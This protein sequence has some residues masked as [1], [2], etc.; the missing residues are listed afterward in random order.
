MS[1]S[2]LSKI[3]ESGLLAGWAT[4]LALLILLLIALMAT[5]APW[6]GTV[7]PTLLDPSIR[8]QGPS[9]EHLLGTDALGR[10]LYSRIVYGARV[11]FVVG[12]GVLAVTAVFGVFFG[13]VSGYF[14]AADAVIMRVMDGIMAIPGILLAI[15]LVAVS[16]AS[17]M[18]VLIAIA[19]P[20]I[21]RMTRLVRGVILSVRSEPYVE[22]ALTLG[23]PTHTIL[24]KHMFPN[25][26]APLIVQGTYVFASAVLL[27]AILSFL[28]AGIPPEIPSW[29]N[30]VAEGRKF[31]Q[32]VPGPVLYP[33][34]FLSIKILSINLL[35]DGLRDALDPKLAARL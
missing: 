6:L 24:I 8:L 19:I 3:R 26:F 13:S 23:T 12:F 35:G 15:A 30:I 7:D 20:E 18:T 11:S 1:V 5:F 27:E 34:L 28:G 14:P 22:A 4:R 32:L 10:D 21:P 31:F 17:L 33:G 2:I 25:T 9:V 16:G 29:G